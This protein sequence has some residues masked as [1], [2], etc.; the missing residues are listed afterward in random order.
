LIVIV[1][2]SYD[3]D[4]LIVLLRHEVPPDKTTALLTIFRIG[5]RKLTSRKG[6][7]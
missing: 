5:K 7:N 2:G 3:V 4:T 6:G 1:S